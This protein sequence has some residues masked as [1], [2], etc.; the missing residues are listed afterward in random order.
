MTFTFNY[1]G[2][3]DFYEPQHGGPILRCGAHHKGDTRCKCEA[4]SPC[5][6][7][8]GEGPSQI[9]PLAMPGLFFIPKLLPLSQ[10]L[11]WGI[12]YSIQGPRRL[13][14]SSIQFYQTSRVLQIHCSNTSPYIYITII[15]SN[16]FVISNQP[17]FFHTF[18]QAY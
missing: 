14:L 8:R 17:K 2:V 13:V 7:P 12:L 4:V 10:N 3:H 15:H 18:Y 1:I 9:G 5:G 11:S 6:P 16:I